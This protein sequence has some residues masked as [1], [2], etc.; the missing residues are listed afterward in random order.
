MKLLI[1]TSSIPFPARHG[2]ELP[3]EKIA[4]HLSRT[5][6]VDL[7]VYGKSDR[8]RKEFECR[9]GAIPDTIRTAVFIPVRSGGAKSALLKELLFI[10]ARF[11]IDGRVNKKDLE[12]LEGRSYDLVWASPLGAVGLLSILK[13]IGVNFSEKLVIGLNDATYGLY[14]N[15][16]RHLIKR[17]LR[18]EWRR[19]I[20][21]IRTPWIIVYERRHLKRASA[22][23][24]QTLLEKKRVERILLCSARRPK[25][26]VAQNGFRGARKNGL[27]KASVRNAPIV[28]FMTHLSGGRGGESKW[29]LKEVW[30]HILRARPDAELW[31]VGSPPDNPTFY[32]KALPERVYIKG[33][34]ADLDACLA[35]ASVG[36]I[37]TLHN[38][39]WVNRVGDYLGAGLPLV[40]CSEPLQTV[41]GLE[42][43]RHAI[44]ADRATEFA[45]AVVELLDNPDQ[46]MRQAK[47]GLI[48]ARNFPSW[49]QTVKVIETELRGIL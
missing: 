31:L 34:A 4:R 37:P 16:V 28:L 22:V 41:T 38:S 44:C 10:K 14:A 35:Q 26:F 27:S 5:H 24:V 19:I 20:N 21:V 36:V 11:I 12:E 40:A 2:V 49:S 9:R 18:D 25:I 29:F 8:D 42:I 43:G 45:N 17:S 7:L 33:Y 48:L 47:E 23:H 30:Q 13:K 15:G 6:T 32:E 1:V 39:G 3:V 46:A